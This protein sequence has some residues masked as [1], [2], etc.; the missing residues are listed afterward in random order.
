MSA[1]DFYSVGAAEQYNW[2]PNTRRFPSCNMLRTTL[3]AI[4]QAVWEYADER[5][6][7]LLLWDVAPFVRPCPEP[8][9]ALFGFG[10]EDFGL[11][12]EAIAKGEDTGVQIVGPGEVSD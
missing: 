1:V 8:S 3:Q 6:A 12:G 7:L 5:S 10:A 4:K 9:A 2:K 11:P